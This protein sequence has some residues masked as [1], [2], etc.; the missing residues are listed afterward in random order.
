MK[1]MLIIIL[2]YLSFLAGYVYATPIVDFSGGVTT[3]GAGDFTVGYTF[4]ITASKTINGLSWWDEAGDGLISDHEVGLWRISDGHL[5]TSTTI[6]NTSTMEASTSGFGNWMVESV[7]ALT[8]AT[9][10]YVIGGVQGNS[11]GG[12]LLRLDT[13]SNSVSGVVYGNS[14]QSAF[15][16]GLTLTMPTR[17]V[18]SADDGTWGPNVH[19]TTVPEPR[20][21][22]LFGFGLL[23][24]VGVSRRKKLF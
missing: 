3:F 5:L 9:G 21:L 4:S 18:L 11:V 23:G 6:T 2:V 24:L 8:L 13:V 15:G 22:A 12:D 17:V 14:I 19:F 1:K 10:D 20:T 7:A 16:S